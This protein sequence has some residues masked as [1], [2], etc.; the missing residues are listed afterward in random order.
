MVNLTYTRQGIYIFFQVHLKKEN[1]EDQNF[2][3]AK[4]YPFRNEIISNDYEIINMENNPDKIDGSGFTISITSGIEENDKKI[5]GAAFNGTSTFEIVENATIFD[6]KHHLQREKSLLNFY[7]HGIYDWIIFDKIKMFLENQ[8]DGEITS[9][10]EKVSELETRVKSLDN[11]IRMLNLKSERPNQLSTIYEGDEGDEGAKNPIPDNIENLLAPLRADIGVLKAQI[12]K[13]PKQENDS[14]IDLDPLNTQIAKLTTRLD[15]F[16]TSEPFN[17]AV[18]SIVKSALVDPNIIGI[19]ANNMETLKNSI[20]DE[21]IRRVSSKITVPT[22]S[23][24]GQLP[25]DIDN[26]INEKIADLKKQLEAATKDATTATSEAKAA[27]GKATTATSEAT[28]ATGKAEAATG[29]AE[30]ATG[31][32]EAATG[33]AEAAAIAATS[34]ATTATSEAK[35]AIQEATEAANKAI[36]EATKAAQE[37]TKAAEEATRKENENIKNLE[38]QLHG[39]SEQLELSNKKYTELDK[40]Y[41]DIKNSE[42]DE[43]RGQLSTLLEKNTGENGDDSQLQFLQSQIESLDA[44]M[45]TDA[46]QRELSKQEHQKYN[47]EKIRELSDIYGKIIDAKTEFERN[48]EE[49]KINDGT[50]EKKIDEALAAADIKIETN[51][52][53]I[54]NALK[55]VGGFEEKL[56]KAEEKYDTNNTKIEN[57]LKTVGGFEEKLKEADGK[58]DTKINNA[59]MKKY[60]DET[61]LRIEKYIDTV[62]A[63]EIEENLNKKMLGILDELKEGNEEYSK[64]VAEF[65]HAIKSINIDPDTLQQIQDELKKLKENNDLNKLDRKMNVIRDSVTLVKKRLEKHLAEVENNGESKSSTPGPNVPETKPIEESKQEHISTKTPAS[66]TKTTIEK[67]QEAME[68]VN[69]TIQ[70]T[71]KQNN[72]PLNINT[73]IN[74]PD[75]EKMNRANEALNQLYNASNP[76]DISD[77]MIQYVPSGINGGSKRKRKSVHSKTKKGGKK[78]VSKKIRQTRKKIVGGGGRGIFTYPTQFNI[79]SYDL[80]ISED[81]SK[82]FYEFF[83]AGSNGDANYEFTTD[84]TKKNQRSNITNLLNAIIKENNLK[85]QYKPGKFKELFLEDYTKKYKEIYKKQEERKELLESNT[86]ESKTSES[87][88]EQESEQKL[89]NEHKLEAESKDEKLVHDSPTKKSEENK[90]IDYLPQIENVEKPINKEAEAKTDHKVDSSINQGNESDY[91]DPPSYNSLKEHSRNINTTTKNLSTGDIS[92]I[93]LQ[94]TNHLNNYLTDA[95]I[96]NYFNNEYAVVC[97]NMRI[98]YYFNHYKL[99]EL[100][101]IPVS[102]EIWKKENNTKILKYLFILV[103]KRKFMKETKMN[104]NA[105]NEFRKILYLRLYSQDKSLFFTDIPHVLKYTNQMLIGKGKNDLSIYLKNIVIQIHS[106]LFNFHDT[107]FIKKAKTYNLQPYLFNDPYKMNTESGLDD[108]FKYIYDAFVNQEEYKTIKNNKTNRIS[109]Y[110]SLLNFDKN[111]SNYNPRYTISTNDGK[112]NTFN[113]ISIKYDAYLKPVIERSDSKPENLSEF[114]YGKFD[115]GFKHTCKKEVQQRDFNDKLN[116]LLKKQ[117]VYIFG[118]G[119]SGSG[120]TTTL[121]YNNRQIFSNNHIEGRGLIPSFIYD[122]FKYENVTLE[123]FEY[124]NSIEPTNQMT[125]FQ[126]VNNNK[127]TYNFEKNILNSKDGDANFFTISETDGTDHYLKNTFN[128]TSDNLSGIVMSFNRTLET[129]K[130]NNYSVDFNKINKLPKIVTTTKIDQKSSI[131]EIVFKKPTGINIKNLEQDINEYNALVE[132]FKKFGEINNNLLYKNGTYKT[133]GPPCNILAQMLKKLLSIL[134]VKSNNKLN[135]IETKTNGYNKLIL[136]GNTILNKTNYS[137]NSFNNDNFKEFLYYVL[138]IRREIIASNEAMVGLIQSYIT[139]IINIKYD[140]ITLKVVISN[141]FDQM[142]SWVQKNRLNESTKSYDKPQIVDCLN[143][144]IENSKYFKFINKI[145]K[146]KDRRNYYIHNQMRIFKEWIIENSKNKDSYGSENIGQEQDLITKIIYL[147]WA[148]TGLLQGQSNMENHSIS[149]FTDYDEQDSEIQVSMYVADFLL[150]YMFNFQLNDEIFKNDDDPQ[151]RRFC[152]Y[153]NVND[154]PTIMWHT[155]D[156]DRNINSTMNN[157]DSSRSHIIYKISHSGDNKN[158][159]YIGDFAGIENEFI[160]TN[161]YTLR[162]FIMQDYNKLTIPYHE[163]LPNDEKIMNL[164]ISI[165]GELMKD[166]NFIKYMYKR[167]KY[168]IPIKTLI[169]EINAAVKPYVLK[170][171][172]TSNAVDA[173]QTKLNTKLIEHKLFGNLF[174]GQRGHIESFLVRTIMG[175]NMMDGNDTEFAK[176]KIQFNKE[177]INPLGHK[178][179]SVEKIITF[180]NGKLGNNEKYISPLA[181]KGFGIYYHNNYNGDMKNLEG[182][183]VTNVVE[184]CNI[185]FMSNPDNEDIYKYIEYL[186]KNNNII[187]LLTFPGFDVTFYKNKGQEIDSLTDLLMILGN[188]TYNTYKFLNNYLLLLHNTY[189]YID[190][191][192][193]EG[194]FINKQLD[195]LVKDVKAISYFQNPGSK[196]PDFPMFSGDKN[197]NDTTDSCFPSNI[198]YSSDQLLTEQKLASELIKCVITDGKN[199]EILDIENN[200]DKQYLKLH[201]GVYGVFNITPDR[202]N[203][204]SDPYINITNLQKLYD[205]E[206]DFLNFQTDKIKNKGLIGDNNGI[207]SDSRLKIYQNVRDEYKELY[208]RI[209]N[210]RPKDNENSVVMNAQIWDKIRQSALW[211]SSADTQNIE[212]SEVKNVLQKIFNNNKLTPIGTLDEIFSY[213]LHKTRRH[214]L[215]GTTGSTITTT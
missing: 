30:A 136:V 43:L 82:K 94:I 84:K 181:S 54:E 107:E 76:I 145:W 190:A 160:N 37:A 112:D 89:E 20:I 186:I 133:L 191:R 154:L 105:F 47:E 156:V 169:N 200:E 67:A 110:L 158:T 26:I 127:L 170:T 18:T 39:L 109:S 14:K 11:N 4:L 33:K 214:N 69:K 165:I 140:N 146:H 59:D 187:E 189:D 98:L 52:T 172:F 206:V 142:N 74:P 212:V 195:S 215:L 130:G 122:N 153:N 16:T 129:I 124:Y 203:P 134:N 184:L 196:Y 9:L 193:I 41:N 148:L 106:R 24:D 157:P 31:K 91:D 213:I 83:D 29:K 192:R 90:S 138:K 163:P 208:N 99:I 12:E 174:I 211:N 202:H 144:I 185:K 103:D 49:A 194:E 118:Y 161:T 128:F 177:L 44:S 48:L 10:R 27:T 40:Q 101:T 117:N 147:K 100:L 126:K 22:S 1:A 183:K 116:E 25:V 8:S 55:Q 104:E 13:L 86:L 62:K 51:K 95:N 114:S 36:K 201:I 42:L 87:K 197:S 88:N 73:S 15:G 38:T 108:N 6:I 209:K 80:K 175:S 3:I 96:N 162:S 50:D 68:K 199:P 75:M 97:T 171:L 139:S 131:T 19:P 17:T 34:E 198:C 132:E 207:Y 121:V 164:N 115:L 111:S 81:Q 182:V 70:E 7:H 92:T 204:P 123:I 149:Q 53:N 93:K 35:K 66:T 61:A 166:V 151:K 57:A 77:E 2:T 65:E 210:M 167:N 71:N 155:V 58:L 5:I 85:S 64:Q 137:E 178:D 205:T 45:K 168:D 179:N 180:E 173:S 72:N 141:V 79:G 78:S 120:K 188:L 56:Q 176:S 119:A 152:F 143:Y 63:P 23:N 135:D 159:L 125:D 46:E 21:V 113:E 60:V 102:H 28:T 32:A 150:L